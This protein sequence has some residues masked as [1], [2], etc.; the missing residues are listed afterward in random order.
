MKNTNKVMARSDNYV[1]EIIDTSFTIPTQMGLDSFCTIH[2]VKHKMSLMEDGESGTFDG[3]VY[4]DKEIV[5]SMTMTRAH[6]EELSKIITTQ[7][8]AFDKEQE[9]K[10]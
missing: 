10:Q 8:Q 2:F 1:S 6:A 9:Q 7:F 5:A 4:L 3:V